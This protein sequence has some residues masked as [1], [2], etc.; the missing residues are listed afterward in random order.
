MAK[1]S[2]DKSPGEIHR[3][4]QQRVVII[5]ADVAGASQRAVTG[6]VKAKMKNLPLP[7]DYFLTF[8]GQSK[9]ITDSFK[10]LGIALLIAVFLVYV[11]MGA[12]FNSFGQPLIIAVT[13]PLALI[14][15]FVGLYLFG[16]SMSMNAILGMIMLVGIVVNNGIL[17]V[18]YINQLRGQ[19][20]DKIDAIVRGGVIRLRPILITSLTTI[21][22]M[23]PIA[24][25]LGEGGEA[26]QSLGAVVV[27]GMMTSTFFT[28]LVIPCVYA[29]FTSGPKRFAK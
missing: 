20:K 29:L 17:L 27:G 9:G 12:Q 15:V 10:S 4:D 14:G 7:P 1:L 19:G 28:L 25:G 18:D 6:R 16:A 3:F 23:L 8:G 26:L 11:V 5:T 21:F 13:I 22:G 24:L 2:F